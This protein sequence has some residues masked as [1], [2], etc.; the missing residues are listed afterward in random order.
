MSNAIEV[1]KTC[2][3]KVFSAFEYYIRNEHELRNILIHDDSAYDVEYPTW[4]SKKFKVNMFRES[5]HLE[6]DIT[7]HEYISDN[8]NVDVFEELSQ[9]ILDN[10]KHAYNKIFISFKVMP[11]SSYDYGG[12][13][14]T[15]LKISIVG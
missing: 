15:E 11:L 3:G 1:A 5:F 12:V 13:C 8:I 6:S 4:M 10:I 2:R 14:D 9:H 7:D